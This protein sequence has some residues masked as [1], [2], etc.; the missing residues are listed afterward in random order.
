MLWVLCGIFV[1]RCGDA[2]GIAVALTLLALHLTMMRVIEMSSLWHD[3]TETNLEV[4]VSP[5]Y[6]PLP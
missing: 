1:C 5:V 3:Y 6:M 2:A 4:I